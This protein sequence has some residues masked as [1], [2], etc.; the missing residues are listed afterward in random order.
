MRT[1]SPKVFFTAIFVFLTTI[2]A[3]EAAVRVRVGHFAPF[4][5]SV[6]ATAVD[7]TLNGTPIASALKYGQVT[8]F[9]GGLSDGNSQLAVLPA[10]SN[11]PV[12]QQT[13]ALLDGQDFTVFI[14]GDGTNQPLQAV[15]VTEQYPPLAS[16][17]FILRFLHAAPTSTDLDSTRVSLRTGDGALVGNVSNFPFG[18]VS[19][20][21]VLPAASYHFKLASPDGSTTLVDTAPIQINA[22]AT[23]YIVATGDGVHQPLG[24]TA[25]PYGALTVIP[26]GGTVDMSAN[27]AWYNPATSG[28]GFTFIPIPS[29]NRLWGTWYTFDANGNPV[30]YSLDSCV[31]P[32][33]TT[34][35]VIGGG[36]NNTHAVLGVTAV[37]HGTF[38]AGTP[39]TITPAGQMTVDFTSCSAATAHYVNGSTDITIN[40][41]N[42]TPAANCTIPASQ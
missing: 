5:N 35:N 7:V 3:A 40:L 12:L 8:D 29:Q 33:Q 6:D 9:V 19:D 39:P 37:P 2:T 22:G 14:L 25:I 16:G 13:V 4:D 36:F 20:A 24:M 41:T 31:T 18:A 42:L 23:V 30:W 10:G 15:V 38:N 11:V 28:Q 32:G 26:G 34:C 1:F 27:G 21:F 17:Q